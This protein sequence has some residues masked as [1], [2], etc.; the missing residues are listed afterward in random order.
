MIVIALDL[1]REAHPTTTIK[2]VRSVRLLP[3][4][5]WPH[6]LIRSSKTRINGKIWA[7]AF[8]LRAQV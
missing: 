7:S 3:L 4:C 2:R 6:A 5:L 8:A 1:K